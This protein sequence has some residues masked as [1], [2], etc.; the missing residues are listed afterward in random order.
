MKLVIPEGDFAGYL[1]DLDGTLVD[2]MPLH[3]MAWR[4][5]QLGAFPW[6][7]RVLQ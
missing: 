5:G 4:D 1:F 6:F 3:F 2:T 7:S